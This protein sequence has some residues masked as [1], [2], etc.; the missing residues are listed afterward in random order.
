[1]SSTR[2]VV[3]TTGSPRHVESTSASSFFNALCGC[4]GRD[5]LRSVSVTTPLQAEGNDCSSGAAAAGA[6]PSRYQVVQFEGNRS[7]GC[8]VGCYK[9]EAS[10]LLWERTLLG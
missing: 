3:R 2:Y 10:A 6:V 4:A 9:G 5:T 8:L 1:M 7:L